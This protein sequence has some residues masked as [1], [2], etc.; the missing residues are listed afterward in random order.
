MTGTFASGVGLFSV[1]DCELAFAASPS[2]VDDNRTPTVIGREEVTKLSILE[3]S[4]V[5]LHGEEMTW[6]DMIVLLGFNDVIMSSCNCS[7]ED[8]V[9]CLDA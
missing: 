4:V 2:G 9:F 5:S 1:E 3:D 8:D 7:N 6:E